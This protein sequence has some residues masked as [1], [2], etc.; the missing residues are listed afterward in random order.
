MKTQIIQLEPHDDTISVRDKMG[1]IQTGRVVLVWPA[2]GHLLDRRLDLVLLLRHSQS[3]GTQIAL[4]TSDPEVRFQAHSLGIPVYK[5]IRK[6]QKARWSR[7]RQSSRNRAWVDQPWQDRLT[8]VQAI[9]ANPPHRRRSTRTLALPLRIGLFALA[10]FAVLSIAAVLI[11]SAEITI[12][13]AIRQQEITLNVRVSD[14]IDQVNLS[15]ILP[16][17]WATTIVEGR[18]S[19]QTTGSINIPADFAEGEV[20]FHNLTD[21]SVTIPEGTVVST[22]DSAHRYATLRESQVPGGANNEVATPIQAILPGSESNLSADRIMLLRANLVYFSLLPT[23]NQYLVAVY[24]SPLP[25]P[26]EIDSNSKNS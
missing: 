5:S 23:L 14:S 22:A 6:A 16:V 4:V 10:V 12:S 18:S 21:Q 25:Q 3:L 13:P 19:V 2:R 20:V 15:G 26:P 17:R 24:L 1:W 8:R 11:P 9:L 7:P